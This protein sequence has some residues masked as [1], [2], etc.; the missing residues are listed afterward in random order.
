MCRLISDPSDQKVF[1]RE[2]REKARKKKES[3]A[4]LEI[5]RKRFEEKREKIRLKKE[6]KKQ[7]QIQLANAEVEFPP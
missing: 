2:K 4:A 3:R 7:K 1:Q 5:E 6:A